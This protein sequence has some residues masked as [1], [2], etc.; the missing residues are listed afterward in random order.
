MREGGLV[1]GIAGWWCL[2]RIYS[3]DRFVWFRVPVEESNEAYVSAKSPE[4]SEDARLPQSHE[5]GGRTQGHR[6]P[7]ASRPQAPG[8]LTFA[9]E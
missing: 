8:R 2:L 7:Q 9:P 1:S 6:G 4:E 3:G 5:H